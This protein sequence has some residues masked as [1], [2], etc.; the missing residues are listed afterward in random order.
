MSL[1]TP[2]RS[3][4][5]AFTTPSVQSA[6]TGITSPTHFGFIDYRFKNEFTGSLTR[7][8]DRTKKD[9]IIAHYYVYRN[10]IRINEFCCDGKLSFQASDEFSPGNYHFE[11]AL[12]EMIP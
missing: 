12:S 5:T 10:V 8:A 11:T 1:S 6:N 7:R 9:V 4:E 3:N 2:T